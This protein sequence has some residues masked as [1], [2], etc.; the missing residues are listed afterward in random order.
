[1]DVS[2]AGL[3][4]YLDDMHVECLQAGPRCS[5]DSSGLGKVKV[6]DSRSS[7]VMYYPAPRVSR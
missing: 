1:M 7:G 2:A 5:M 3:A 4:T 6:V